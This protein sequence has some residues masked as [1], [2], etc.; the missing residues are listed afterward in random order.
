M[1][2]IDEDVL[3]LRVVERSLQLMHA[4]QPPAYSGRSRKLT[5][6]EKR[7]LAKLKKN[8]DRVTDAVT[9]ALREGEIT[10]LQA[11]ESVLRRLNTA[12]RAMQKAKRYG[13][14]TEEVEARYHSLTNEYL[15]YVLQRLAINNKTK[16]E[17]SN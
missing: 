16:V 13:Q 5:R 6:K 10:N 8:I 2:I 12:A 1:D 14:V 15:D 7:R 4:R 9:I 17:R 11:R 3:S